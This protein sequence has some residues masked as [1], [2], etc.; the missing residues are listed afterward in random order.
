MSARTHYRVFNERTGHPTTDNRAR[1]WN[2]R[3]SDL[4]YSF[5]LR[6]V[7]GWKR[8][9]RLSHETYIQLVKLYIAVMKQLESPGEG[10]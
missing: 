10:N 8:K 2:K 3:M 1:Q 9:K 5:R 4:R 7:K 6:G